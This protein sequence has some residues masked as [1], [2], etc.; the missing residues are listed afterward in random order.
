ME[1]SVDNGCSR[2]LLISYFKYSSV[3]SK[4]LGILIILLRE[5]RVAFLFPNSL[6]ICVSSKR[7]S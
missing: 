2:S 1:L 3:I 6:N 4:F 7:A 5:E